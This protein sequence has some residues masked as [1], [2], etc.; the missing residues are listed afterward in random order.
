M[1]KTTSPTKRS[2]DNLLARYP[3]VDKVEKRIPHTFI[4][5]DL[6][7]FADLI[8][9]NSSE[10]VLVQ[11]TTKSHVGARREKILASA[12]ARLWVVGEHRR[13]L[14][15]GW[16]KVGPRGG[17]KTWTLYEEEITEMDFGV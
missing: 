1:A 5:Q 13:I 3:F 17:L 7:G 16:S 10:T 2:T 12:E 6:F 15:H 14:I 9:I 4:T 8:A 11:T